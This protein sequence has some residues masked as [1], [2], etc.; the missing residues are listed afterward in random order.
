MEITAIAK[1]VVGQIVQNNAEGYSAK[2]TRIVNYTEATS[3]M[4]INPGREFMT[5][6]KAKLGENY[7]ELYFEV[8]LQII[9][10]QPGSTFKIGQL[11]M[12]AWDELTD[13]DLL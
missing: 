3:W 13:C 5:E 12:L 8:E 1:P 6:Q 10:V 9:D 7:A 2:V 11:E 4:D